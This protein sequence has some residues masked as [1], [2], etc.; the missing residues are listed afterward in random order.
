MFS[1]P[2]STRFDVR[3]SLLAVPIRIHPMFWLIVFLLGWNLT[4]VEQLLWVGVVF[5]SI[6][7]HELGHALSARAFGERS[8]VVLYSLG[9]LTIPETET[10][11]SG[12]RRYAVIAFCGPAAG[13]LLALIAYLVIPQIGSTTSGLLGALHFHLVQVNVVWGLA[14]LLPIWPLDGGQV[15]RT[16]LTHFTPDRGYAVASVVSLVTAAAIVL[17]A[18]QIGRPLVALFAMY[19]ALMEWR[20]SI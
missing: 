16:L 2:P 20:R 13:F 10:G 15:A 8:H 11:T 6:L 18:W 17:I 14:N 5:V 7:V 1:E 9:G 3:F 4:R 19:F 12:G